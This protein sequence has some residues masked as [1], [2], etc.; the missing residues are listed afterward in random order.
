MHEEVFESNVLEK[1]VDLLTELEILK[2]IEKVCRFNVD[3][4]GYEKH[5]HYT[6]FRL[7]HFQEDVEHDFSFVD[8]V[9]F[10]NDYGFVIDEDASTK[11]LGQHRTELSIKSV[12]FDYS[13]DDL[14]FDFI[15][16]GLPVDIDTIA[17]TNPFEVE[18]N[19]IGCLNDEMFWKQSL[20]LSYLMYKRHNLISC[21]MHLFIAFEGLIRHE[22]TDTRSNVRQIFENYT[23]NELPEYLDAYRKIRNT[24]MHG[25]EN[26]ASLLND[27]DISILLT[28]IDRLRVKECVP[29]IVD[30]TWAMDEGVKL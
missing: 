24:V 5:V 30:Y 23:G 1:F 9:Q 25:N 16:E 7:R 27:D 26:I 14:I 2:S 28:V 22:I 10:L 15:I 21:F 18:L 11:V 8:E 4:Y 13:N 6:E 17:D 20:Y 29:S 19:I 3:V 12:T